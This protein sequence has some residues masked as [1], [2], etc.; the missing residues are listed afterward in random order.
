MLIGSTAGHESFGEF[1]EERWNDPDLRPVDRTVKFRR[2][3]A[4]PDP[5]TEFAKTWSRRS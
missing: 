3:E 1:L 2:P 4:R 5:I